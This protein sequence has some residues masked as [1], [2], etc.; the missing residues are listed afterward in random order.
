MLAS[1]FPEII[2]TNYIISQCIGICALIIV[3]IGYFLKTRQNFFITQIIGNCLIA[4][5]YFF[6]GTFF[7]CIGVAIACVRSIIF[8]VYEKKGKNVPWWLIGIICM[9]IIINCII[10]WSGPLD[11]LPLTSLM[12]FTIAFR[13]KNDLILK[14]FLLL[15]CFMFTTFTICKYDYSGLILKIFEINVIIIA[16]IK[17]YINQ[18]RKIKA[19]IKE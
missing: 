2:T 15:A 10:F 3:C 13:I 14:S 17:I 7:T 5:S 8:Y 16:M 4:T 18:K 6:L 11:L 9:V 12:I 19:I 1:I